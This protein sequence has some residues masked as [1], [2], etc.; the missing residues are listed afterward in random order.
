MNY[1][2]PQKLERAQNV[3]A[4]PSKFTPE[5]VERVAL[6]KV[7]PTL[8]DELKVREVYKI[9]GGKLANDGDTVSVTVGGQEKEYPVTGTPA[10][11][12]DAGT[13]RKSRTTK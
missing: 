13:T 1:I 5:S 9:I 7:D 2:N 8:S 10:P 11:E 12:G 4:D 3:V 6:G